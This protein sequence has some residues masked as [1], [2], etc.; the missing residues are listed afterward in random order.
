MIRYLYRT[1]EFEKSLHKLRK[2]RGEAEVAVKRLDNII[3]RLLETGSPRWRDIGK[4][5]KHGENRSKSCKKFDLGG[6]YRLVFTVRNALFIL[7]FVG[8]HDECDRWAKRNKKFTIDVSADSSEMTLI[9]KI[10]DETENMEMD[11]EEDYDQL[12][13]EKMD[14]KILRRVFSALCNA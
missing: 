11:H 5:T 6:G 14:D 4:L 10:I 8:T 9:A 7:L 1:Q 2:A 13:M 12:L 3:N